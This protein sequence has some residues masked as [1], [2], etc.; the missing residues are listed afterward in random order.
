MTIEQMNKRIS[1]IEA[2][3][4]QDKSCT[5]ATAHPL[6]MEYENLLGLLVEVKQEVGQNEGM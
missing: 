6:W 5:D 4:E 3:I 1:E 2:I